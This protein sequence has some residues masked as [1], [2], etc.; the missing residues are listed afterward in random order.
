MP[1]SV[2]F[3]AL[4]DWQALHKGEAFTMPWDGTPWRCGAAC[5]ALSPWKQQPCRPA[6]VPML[7]AQLCCRCGGRVCWAPVC[8]RSVLTHCFYVRA[9]ALCWAI[10]SGGLGTLSGAPP[11]CQSQWSGRGTAQ[12]ASKSHAMR[13]RHALS[14]PGSDAYGRQH[15]FCGVR[16]TQPSL[17][18][19]PG[20]CSCT[21]NC[22]CRMPR[23][24]CCV[25]PLQER[26]G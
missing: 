3:N 16:S 2:F 5:R 9:G 7:A 19:Q 13:C 24:H 20:S 17:T 8:C 25:C 18:F 1:A 11:G 22:I 10:D 6:N 23:C 26:P 15:T 21:H 14:V 4:S 12:T